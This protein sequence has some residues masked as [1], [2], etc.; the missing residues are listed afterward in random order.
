M[1]KKAT[2]LS[3]ELYKQLKPYIDYLE[4][5][6][7][8]ASEHHLK[9][10]KP[11]N[12]YEVF[13]GWYYKDGKDQYILADLASYTFE[14]KIE[15]YKYKIVK[16]KKTKQYELENPCN[17]VDDEYSKYDSVIVDNID[18]FK[19]AIGNFIKTLKNF[20]I[21]TKKHEMES[22]FKH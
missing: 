15:V 7:C 10:L 5:L 22:D 13:N 18:D 8:I 14:P 2:K 21:K 16:N 9:Y 3:P 17:F 20:K 4:S 12:Y 6:H 19:I 11:Q 1:D